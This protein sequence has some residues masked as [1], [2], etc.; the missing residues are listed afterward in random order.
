MGCVVQN[1][2]ISLHK[3]KVTA[4]PSF[5]LTLSDSIL[6]NLMTKIII[7]MIIKNNR[8]KNHTIFGRFVFSKRYF[9]LVPFLSFHM[10]FFQS[11]LYCDISQ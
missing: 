7:M 3:K 1:S 8:E 5:I 11:S 10:F 6:S 9:Q 4:S 2:F